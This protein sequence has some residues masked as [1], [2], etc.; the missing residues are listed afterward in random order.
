[1]KSILYL[2]LTVVVTCTA[3]QQYYNNRYD[4]LNADSIVQND[5]VLLAYFKCVMD[6]GPCTKDGKNF[7][8]EFN[9][10]NFWAY[11]NFV[12][13][14]D[15]SSPL[16]GVTNTA[17]LSYVNT[18]HLH[19]VQYQRRSFKVMFILFRKFQ[20]KIRCG[21]YLPNSCYLMLITRIWT[22][23]GDFNQGQCSHTIK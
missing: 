9:G 13:L 20:I 7:K 3:Q 18:T 1:M 12:I 15:K 22:I 23:R 5:R 4:N 2:V 19:Y 16:P 21:Q 17:Y 11:E 6:K 8:R 10:T 14:C